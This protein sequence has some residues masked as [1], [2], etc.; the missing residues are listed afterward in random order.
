[1]LN[2]KIR[3]QNLCFKSW[4]MQEGMRWNRLKVCAMKVMTVGYS[5]VLERF[6]FLIF[7]IVNLVA[8]CCA[9]LTV[10]QV[11]CLMHEDTLPDAHVTLPQLCHLASTFVRIGPCTQSSRGNPTA[12]ITHKRQGGKIVKQASGITF[13]YAVIYE[14]EIQEVCHPSI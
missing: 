6:S 5:S 12:S 4:K 9:G 14:H 1:M 2:L 7:L 11:V 8:C 10:S 13:K 3:I